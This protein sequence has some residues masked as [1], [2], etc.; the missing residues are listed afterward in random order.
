[1]ENELKELRGELK[2]NKPTKKVGEMSD[3]EVEE[4]L[5]ASFIHKQQELDIKASYHDKFKAILPIKKVAKFY[6]LEHEFHRMNKQNKHHPGP[7][8]RHNKGPY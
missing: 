5:D 8:P 4:L 6:H 7:P 2:K 3:K 1:M